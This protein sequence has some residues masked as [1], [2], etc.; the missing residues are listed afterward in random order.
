MISDVSKFEIFLWTNY[1]YTVTLK[2]VLEFYMNCNEFFNNT[3]EIHLN[4]L[5]LLKIYFN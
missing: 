1:T 4:I 5:R 2:T 3:V